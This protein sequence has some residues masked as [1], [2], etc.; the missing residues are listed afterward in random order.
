MLFWAI[1]RAFSCGE[2]ISG[3]WVL[4]CFILFSS[5]FPLKRFCGNYPFFL[6]DK[7]LGVCVLVLCFDWIFYLSLL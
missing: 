6:L 1:S 4:C 7:M 5:L 2:N 3:F